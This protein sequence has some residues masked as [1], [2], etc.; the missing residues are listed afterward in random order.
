MCFEATHVYT[1]N[2]MGHTNILEAYTE[3]PE[4]ASHKL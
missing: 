1:R 2:E 4:S 3:I